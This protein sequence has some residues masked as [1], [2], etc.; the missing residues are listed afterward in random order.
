MFR[1]LKEMFSCLIYL[2]LCCF[3]V[4]LENKDSYFVYSFYFFGMVVFCSFLYFRVLW[5]G[6]VSY[7][8]SYD[9]FVVM[10]YVGIGF[11]IVIYIFVSI[12]NVLFKLF[13]VFFLFKWE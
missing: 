13:F 11:Y 10:E 3:G 4:V 2:V 1:I 6:I 9:I 7:I 8:V 12:L 5:L